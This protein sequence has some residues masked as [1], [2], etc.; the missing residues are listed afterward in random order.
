MSNITE[1]GPKMA[2]GAL[3]CENV[4]GLHHSIFLAILNF[5]FSITACLGNV[6]ILIALQKKSSLHPPSKLMFRCLALTDLCVGL[7]TQPMFAAELITEVNELRQICNHIGTVVGISGIVFSGV[8]LMTLTAISVD[9]L[10]A[11]SLSMRYRQVVKLRRVGGILAFFWFLCISVP[12][13][14]QLTGLL[15]FSNVTSAVILLCLMISVYCYMRIYLR[16]RI[17]RTQ[18]EHNDNEIGQ[19]N[20]EGIPAWNIE[21][22]KKTVS[23]AMWVQITLLTCYLPYAMLSFET[24]FPYSA[25]SYVIVIRYAG[26][27]ALLNS[28]LNPFLYCWKMTEMRQAVKDI[29]D[30]Y[31]CNYRKQ[32]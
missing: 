11:L 20:R 1:N 12:L 21:K 31:R 23:A 18:I 30:R 13:M 24:L 15:F 5:I 25:V 2:A 10:L 6:L 17:N 22:Y 4:L 29:I 27:L 7:I 3:Y 14:K 32:A 28:S 9:R 8:S 19:R 16:L 26:S